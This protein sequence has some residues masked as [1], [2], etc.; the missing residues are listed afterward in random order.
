[1]AIV[2]LSDVATQVYVVLG[3]DEH[4]HDQVLA[5]VRTFADAKKYCVET[6][7][8]EPYFDVWIEKHP[9]L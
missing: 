1:M 8:L 3:I 5:V 4:Q 2:S 6:L 9:V 7:S